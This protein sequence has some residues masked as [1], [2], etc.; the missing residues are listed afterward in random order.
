MPS[1]LN[2]PL[3]H[4]F[5]VTFTGN[6]STTSEAQAGATVD[7]SGLSLPIALIDKIAV[8][9]KAIDLA[10]ELAGKDED[11]LV[12][13]LEPAGEIIV[14]AHRFLGLEDIHNLGSVADCLR[15]IVDTFR[16]GP[17]A[18][19]GNGDALAFPALANPVNRSGNA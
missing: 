8:T 11:R 13:L 9:L 10:C 5:G 19:P 15:D 6:P 1:R 2:K 14:A 7:V 16:A 3:N 12:S 4:R 18:Q 17:D